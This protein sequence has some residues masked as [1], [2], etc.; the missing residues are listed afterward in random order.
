MFA[1]LEYRPFLKAWLEARREKE[2][3]YSYAKF[4]DAGGCSKAALANVLS[5]ARTPRPETIDAFARAMELSPP[6][7]NYLGLLVDLELAR[8]ASHRGTV[9]G[10]ILASERFGQLRV[11]ETRPDSELFRFLEHWYIGAILELVGLSG[12]GDPQWLA[13]ALHPPIEPAEAASALHTLLDMEFLERREDGSLHKREVRFRTEPEA[14]LEATVRFHRDVLP[15]L[16]SQID[17]DGGDQR[18]VLA[19]TI[20]LDEALIPE[21]KARLNLL[22]EQLATLADDPV[23]SGDRRVYQVAVQLLPL[24][25]S[26]PPSGR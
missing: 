13:G 1:Y 10:R 25:E 3:S 2:P 21:A 17:L 22:V 8:D 26:I 7:R 18:H 19:A 4:A 15:G 16:M 24:S 20:T 9:M 11:A 5:G 12:S 23:V 14:D 6:E